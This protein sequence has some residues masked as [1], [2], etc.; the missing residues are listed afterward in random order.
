MVKEIYIDNLIK[1]MN[2]A[3]HGRNSL[4]TLKEGQVRT[5]RKVSSD[6]LEDNVKVKYQIRYSTYLYLVVVGASV[7]PYK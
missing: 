7:M 2:G 1:L 6:N 4:F 5:Y 3:R